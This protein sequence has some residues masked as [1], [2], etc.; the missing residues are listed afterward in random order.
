[1]TIESNFFSFWVSNSGWVGSLFEGSGDSL[2]RCRRFIKADGR[3]G[4][5]REKKKIKTRFVGLTTKCSC[6]GL[7]IKADGQ[8]GGAREKKKIKTR[9][10]GLTT[11]CVFFSHHK[12]YV[13]FFL[14]RSGP[15]ISFDERLIARRTITVLRTKEPNRAPQ[16]HFCGPPL[17]TPDQRN[18]VSCSPP[19]ADP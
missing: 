19:T 12:K 5:A 13:F 14:S 10:V 15:S 2:S 17:K 7:F 18:V 1:M 3:S 4:G 9:F 11:K 6:C 16:I 8:S